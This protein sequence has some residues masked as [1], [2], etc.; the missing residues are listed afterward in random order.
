MS[1]ALNIIHA[2]LSHQQL[3]IIITITIIIAGTGSRTIH[4][5]QKD[6]ISHLQLLSITRS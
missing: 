6:R 5:A 2:Y 3:F 1:P 4:H